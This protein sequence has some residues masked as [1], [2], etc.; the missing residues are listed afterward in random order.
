MG[1]WPYGPHNEITRS[2]VLKHIH[3]VKNGTRKYRRRVPHDLQSVLGKKEFIRVLGKTD[4]EV[5]RN[6]HPYHEHVEQLLASVSPTS[7]AAELASIK[8]NIEV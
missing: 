5:M 2:L 6:Y 1:L 4:T 3:I 8:T 7:D